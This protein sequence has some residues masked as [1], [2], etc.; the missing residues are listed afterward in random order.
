VV[1]ERYTTVSMLRTIG[2]VLGLKPLGLNDALAVP[3]SQAFD[4]RQKEW[5]FKAR[6][7]EVLRQTQLPIAWPSAQQKAETGTP[8]PLRSAAYW[9]AAMAGQNFALE[10]RLDTDAFNA[11]LWA[12]L[13]GRAPEA[14]VRSGLNLSENREQLLKLASRPCHAD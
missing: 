9:Q 1:S 6:P 12:G 14:S 3:M 2:A 5:T 13:A 11:A 4:L 10:D 8:C 7:S